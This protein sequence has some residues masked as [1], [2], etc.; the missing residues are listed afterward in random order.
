MFKT[1]QNSKV[2][3]LFFENNRI[4]PKNYFHQL[5]QI[6]NKNN[7]NN[8]IKTTK[9]NESLKVNSPQNLLSLSKESSNSF[10]VSEFEEKTNEIKDNK[11][12]DE[13]IFPLPYFDIYDYSKYN[14]TQ[15]DDD[16]IYYEENKKEKKSKI[17]QDNVD[18]EN[19]STSPT[20]PNQNLI[21]LVKKAKI[22]KNE[23]K[24]TNNYLRYNN[25]IKNNK[26]NKNYKNRKSPSST[27]II[28]ERSR[29]KYN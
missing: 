2:N 25:S 22:D 7:K 8:N 29:T 18:E 24:R 4:D 1:I 12:C 28:R 3:L 6:K 19:N 21:E 15:N 11:N 23:R 27:K 10:S 16:E 5:N 20:E 9:P 14:Q 13:F 17:G 26:N